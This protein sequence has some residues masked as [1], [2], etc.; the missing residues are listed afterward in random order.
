MSF[1][2]TTVSSNHLFWDS[3]NTPPGTK[4]LIKAGTLPV[5]HGL[6][7]LRPSHLIYVLGGKVANLVEKWEL[8]KVI[9][10]LIRDINIYYNVNSINEYRMSTGLFLL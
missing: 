5:S 10:I 6:L 3:L 9:Y 7:L 8:N 1:F 2:L 4:I